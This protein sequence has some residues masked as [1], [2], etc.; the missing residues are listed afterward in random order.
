MCI[1]DSFEEGLAQ[2]IDA[3]HALLLQHFP[4]SQGQ[5]NPNELPNRADL[6]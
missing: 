3:V 6:R 5:A 1:R 2:A 4:L